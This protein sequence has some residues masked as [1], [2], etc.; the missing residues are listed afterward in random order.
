MLSKIEILKPVPDL[1]L[2]M[3]RNFVPLENLK[4]NALLALAI[5]TFD[6]WARMLFPRRQSCK[7]RRG[8]RNKLLIK[9]L[10]WERWG[11]LF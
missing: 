9:R 8:V 3:M 2:S 7:Q 5:L 11:L 6:N 10:L 1:F 4:S